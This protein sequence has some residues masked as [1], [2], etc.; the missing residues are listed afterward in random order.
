MT[1]VDGCITHP[2]KLVLVLHCFLKE[3]SAGSENL[4]MV[5]L[6]CFPYHVYTV[7]KMDGQYNESMIL[8]TTTYILEFYSL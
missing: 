8:T 5:L 7:P 1:E 3:H 2:N 6:L 4:G